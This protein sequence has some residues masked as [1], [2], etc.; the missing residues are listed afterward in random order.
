VFLE[1]D[2]WE[3]SAAWYEDDIAEH[4][5]DGQGPWSATPHFESCAKRNGSQ[6]G[7]ETC[8]T[9][10]DIVQ[11][12]IDSLGTLLDK[13]HVDIYA[14]GHVHSYSTT[15]P[16]FGGAVTKKSY[17]DPKGTV[18]L[19]EGNGGVPGV[20]RNSATIHDCKKSAPQEPDSPMDM[21]RICGSGMNYGRLVTSNASVLTYEHVD[22][23]N[24]N[25]TDTWSIV[26]T[27][28]TSF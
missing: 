10:K 5:R 3:A 4:E 19:L 12:S 8:T 14:A 26:K 13:Y 22:N 18:H 17:V 16:L 24:G 20:F 27:E 11:A 23:E 21:F 15:W 9:V 7:N 28:M 6:S 2:A 25:I 1:E